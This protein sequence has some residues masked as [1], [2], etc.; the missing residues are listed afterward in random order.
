MLESLWSQI[1]EAWRSAAWLEIVA[2]TLA[3]L[4]VVLAIRQQVACWLAAF[5]SSCLYVAVLFN[6]R[7]YMESALNVFYAA[8]AIYGYWRWRGGRRQ[9]P[10]TVKRWPLSH[11]LLAL[12]AVVAASM[13]SSNLLRGHTAAAWPFADSMVTW[14]SVF[15][16]YLVAIKVYENWHWW[17]VIDASAALLYVTRH[18]YVTTLLFVLYLVLIVIGAHEWKKVLVPTAKADA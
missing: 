17:F 13:V 6:A 11:H 9:R 14:A 5:V 18:L 1:A 3:L 2:A 10:L 12:M 7:L 8:M 4:Y 16:T 15:A